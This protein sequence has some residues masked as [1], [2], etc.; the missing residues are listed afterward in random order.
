METTKLR[1]KLKAQFS[2]I[3]EDDKNLEYLERIF[4]N[5]N[6]EASSSQVPEWHW[7]EVEARRRRHLSGESKS[8]SW[9]EVKSDIREKYGS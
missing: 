7:K 2:E 9:E 3:I 1:K 5:L 6:T 4:E 8:Y